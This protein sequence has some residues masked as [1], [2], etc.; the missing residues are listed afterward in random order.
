VTIHCAQE[1]LENEKY[2]RSGGAEAIKE[3]SY[4]A[5]LC[6]RPLHVIS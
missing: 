1:T 3:V 5:T 6:W 4:L 2:W